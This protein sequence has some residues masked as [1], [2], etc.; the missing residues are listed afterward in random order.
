M[1]EA[2]DALDECEMIYR[3]LDLTIDRSPSLAPLHDI[4]EG[5]RQ[6]VAIAQ[7]TLHAL[8][9]QNDVL[10]YSDEW[11]E[12]YEDPELA[13]NLFD[14][15]LPGEADTADGVILYGP[16][17]RTVERHI[18]EVSQLLEPLANRLSTVPRTVGRGRPR[19]YS[20]G[21]AILRL[22]DIYQRFGFDEPTPTTSATSALNAQKNRKANTV[23]YRSPFL[24]FARGFLRSVEGDARPAVG[25]HAF[26]RTVQD[27]LKIWKVDP[28]LHA[29]VNGASTTNDVLKFMDAFDQRRAEVGL[30]KPKKSGR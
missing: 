18:R 28:G 25:E 20:L 19:K 10:M 24:Q 6:Q 1:N 26:A 7:E 22:A 29:L 13:A 16:L 17:L 3:C 15:T 14:A 9:T 5:F 27:S 4:V 11:V 21:F 23:V 2:F 12:V 8:S 30:H